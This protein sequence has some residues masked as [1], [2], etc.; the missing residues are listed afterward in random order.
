VNW[1]AISA[2]ENGPPLLVEGAVMD[3]PKKGYFLD[4]G[5]GEMKLIL[6]L[7]INCNFIPF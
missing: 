1:C 6:F 5:I 3:V 2:L 4:F 7:F